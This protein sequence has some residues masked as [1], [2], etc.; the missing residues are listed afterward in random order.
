MQV[1]VL[2]SKYVIFVKLSILYQLG[3]DFI[4]VRYHILEILGLLNQLKTH[5]SINI[6]ERWVNNHFIDSPVINFTIYHSNPGFCGIGLVRLASIT[7]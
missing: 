1:N 2:I 7:D 6:T 5:L 4:I 3:F